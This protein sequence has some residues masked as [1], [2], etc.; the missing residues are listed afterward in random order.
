MLVYLLKKE[1]NSDLKIK[2]LKLD[3]NFYKVR[4]KVWAYKLDESGKLNLLL[5][6]PFK[7]KKEAARELH[8]HNSKVNE[9]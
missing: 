5:N 4:T 9:Y 6:Q 3:L 8:I 7:T 2:L 1:I